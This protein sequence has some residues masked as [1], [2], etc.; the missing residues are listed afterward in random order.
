MDSNPD[1]RPRYEYIVVGSGAGGGT[2]AARLA[3]A[4]CSVLLLE[5]GGDPKQLSGGDAV[6][7]DRLTEDYEVPVFHAFSTENEAIRW[8]F[9]PQHYSDPAT[10]R[11]DPKVRETPDGPGVLYPRAGTLGGCTAHNAMIMVYPH[12]ADWDDLAYRT[13]DDSWTARR[14]RPYFQ[15]LENCRYRGFHRLLSKLGINFTRHGFSGWLDTERAVPW[16]ALKD[17]ELVTVLVQTIRNDVRWMGMRLRRLWWVLIGLLDPNDWRLVKDNAVGLRYTPLSTRGHARRGTREFLREVEAETGRLT[18][19]LDAL[20]TRVLFDDENRAI[21]VEYLKGERLYEAH[22]D[23]SPGPGERRTARACCEVILAGGAFNTPQLLMLSGIGPREELE[24]HG[25]PVR[26]HSPGVGTN[27]QDRYEVGVINRMDSAEWEVLHG[28]RYEKGDPLYRMWEG[29]RGWSMRR[30]RRGVY[31]TNGAVAAIIRRSR[32]DRWLPDLFCFAVLGRFAGYQP[33][34]SR[35]VLKPNYLTWAILKAHTNNTAGTVRL[36]SND[37]RHRPLINFRY[38]DEGNDD[39]KADVAAVVDGIEFVR[40]LTAP[41]REK[42]LIVEEELPGDHVKTRNDLAQ[43]VKDHA[44]GHHASC[45]CSIGPLAQNGVV[46]GDFE[47]HGTKG[48]RVVDASVFPKIPGFFIVTSVYMI[49]EKA[50]DVILAAAG[51]PPLDPGGGGGFVRLLT[52]LL[53]WLGI[54]ALAAVGA[55]LLVLVASWLY[56]ERASR[57]VDEAETSREIVRTLTDIVEHEYDPVFFRRDTHPKANACVDATFYVRPDLDPRAAQGA[58]QPGRTYAAYLRFS[59]AANEV[60]PDQEPDFRGLGIKLRDVE[61]ARLPVPSGEPDPREEKHS[62]D[63]LFIAHNAF[64]AGNT[65]HFLDF[66]QACRAGGYSCAPQSLPV[67]WH[68]LTHPRGLIWNARLNGLRSYDAIDDI[69]WYSVAPFRLGNEN[70]IVKYGVFPEGES[71]IPGAPLANPAPYDGLGDSPDYLTER[72]VDK[73]TRRKE[74]LRLTFKLQFRDDPE[75]QPI[76]DT[77]I[78]WEASWVEVA[79]IDIAP[80]VFDTTEKWQRCQDVTFNPWHGLVAHEPV[81]GI[82][83]A[84][85]DVMHALQAVRRRHNDEKRLDF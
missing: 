16:K 13:G 28:A 85:R 51:K 76:D 59:N 46:N 84:R 4:G 1:E 72:L 56:F 33:D 80:Q 37:P 67:I 26:F 55:A 47:V 45:T 19:E 61:G 71:E 54:L 75:T 14:M 11:R 48:L 18:I 29:R 15:R 20:V 50:A 9:Y 78:P 27:L 74:H 35:D 82:N 22:A 7:P 68:V 81:G 53:K 32:R 36:R 5:A 23:P 38:F 44:W 6:G 31:T 52:R 30:K 34:Y 66:F 63:F 21:G 43:F 8:D 10:Q 12:N 25:I 64:F 65:Q 70:N 69:R 62:Q 17:G 60:T 58:F 49:A 41:A 79:T 77:L 2:L 40:K 42:G 3:Q 83:R 57:P 73:L 24:R 39:E